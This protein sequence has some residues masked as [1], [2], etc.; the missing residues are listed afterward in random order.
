MIVD[1][2]S[3][4]PHVVS[5]PSG[6]NDLVKALTAYFATFGV[7]AELCTDGGPEFVAKKTKEFL[8]R[9]GVNH[10]LSSAYNP[11]SN[12]RAE[13]AVKS[14]KRLLMSHTDANGCIDTEAVAAGLLQYR[15][16]PDPQ[17]SLSPAQIVFGR[18]MRDL[19]P[20]EPESP[21]FSNTALAGCLEQTRG[22]PAC[23]LCHTGRQDAEWVPKSTTSGTG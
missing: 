7:C 8:K 6:A 15:N 23:S 17:S 3:A 21:I 19:M 4:W 14:M 22:C 11:E 5:Q 12:G 18:N 2:F 9:W 20:V 16:T 13:A 1:R 10:R